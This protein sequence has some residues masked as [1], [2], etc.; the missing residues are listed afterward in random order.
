M[1]ER[2]PDV[3]RL[4]GGIVRL[5]SKVLGLSLGVLFGLAIF[6]ATNWLVLKGGRRVGPHLSLLSQYFLGYR[7][8][9][10]GSLIGGAYGFA[11]GTL[12]GSL[13][14]WVYNA[15]AVLRNKGKGAR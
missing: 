3:E 15:I 9:F 12:A 8:S 1:K 4:L 5:N 13:M 6:V 7:V 11:I 2:E 14:G 10:A